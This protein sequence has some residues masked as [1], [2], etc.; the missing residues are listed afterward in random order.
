MQ[1]VLQEVRLMVLRY[2]SQTDN[3][4]ISH[5]IQVASLTVLIADSLDISNR[6]NPY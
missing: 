1:Q 4:Q 3:S 6:E 5:T 2:F